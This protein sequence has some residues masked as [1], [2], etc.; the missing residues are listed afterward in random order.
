MYVVHRKSHQVSI[1]LRCYKPQRLEQNGRHRADDISKCIILIKNICILIKNS[2]EFFPK[3]PFDNKSTLLQI[4]A[5]R[6]TGNK[7]LSDPILT[8]FTD[9]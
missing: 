7:P 6:Q 4:M 3:H 9:P 1:A 2:L 5:W 8:H